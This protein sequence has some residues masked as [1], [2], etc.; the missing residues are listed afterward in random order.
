MTHG[1]HRISRWL[2]A[3][4]ACVT[5]ALTGCSA[6]PPEALNNSAKALSGQIETDRKALDKAKTDFGNQLK[7][8]KYAFMNAYTP[9]ERHADRFDQAKTKLDEADKVLKTE[10]KPLVDDYEDGKKAK[11]EAAIGK[12]N[13]LRTDAQTL[14]RD[15]AQWADKVVAT[16]TDPKGTVKASADALTGM[17]TDYDP[18]NKRVETAQS[19]YERNKAAIGTAFQPLSNQHSDALQA[20]GLLQAEASKNPPNY[21]VMTTHSQTVL[22]NSAA[23]G[24]DAP[25]FKS[26]LG[27]LDDRETHTLVDIRVDS[28]VEINRTSWDE[29]YDYPDEHN[30]DYPGVPVDMDT[31][32]YFAKFGPDD[33]L[34]KEV[35]GWGG[36]FKYD[37]VDENQWKKLGIES[38]KDWPKGDSDAEF[39]VELDETYCHQV[40]IWKNGKAGSQPAGNYCSKYDTSTDKAAGKYWIEADDLDAELIGMDVYAKGVGDF[41]DQATTEG[42][43]PGMAYVGDP[44]AGEWREDSNGNSFWHYY[45]QY[46]FFSQLIGGPNSYHYRSEYDSWNRD[47][48]YS[49]RPYFAS[50]NGKDRYGL[51]SPLVTS[52]FPGS[53]YMSSGLHN[54]TVRGAGPA[55]RSG[56]PG[57]GGK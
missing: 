57:N 43:P 36:G 3:L 6:E 53:T 25:A 18:L 15:P 24:K 37:K 31:A 22:N 32:N 2:I 42:T 11:L 49:K 51:K 50:V 12:V 19:T 4:L 28:V 20:N 5:L 44:Q 14:T 35:S 56:G 1:N 29:S 39:Y 8:D 16:K 38:K 46:M 13:T 52:R 40:L 30:Y 27:Q 41:N 7:Q 55:A 34:A 9:A 10:V 45:G 33:V 47:Y 21:A 54:S 26:R 17:N 23:Y 48:R